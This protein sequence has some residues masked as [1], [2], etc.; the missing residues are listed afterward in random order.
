MRESELQA[1]ISAATAYEDFFL[2]AVFSQW[3]GKV[4]DAAEIQSGKPGEK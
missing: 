3:A 4:V 1:Q 2:P